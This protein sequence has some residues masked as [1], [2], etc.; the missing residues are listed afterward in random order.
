MPRGPE[1]GS[2]TAWPAVR[3]A[4]LAILV[5]VEAG[6][7]SDRLLQARETRFSDLR[8]RRFMHHLVLTTLRWQEAL[9]RRL[10][11]WVR[12][13]WERLD[14]LTRNALRLGLAQGLLLDRPAP[15][16]VDTTIEAAKVAGVGRAAG[17]IN[18]VLRRAL[19]D[20][21]PLDP[22][23]TVPAWLLARWEQAFGEDRTAGIVHAI[24]EPARPFIVVRPDRGT[25]AELA[26]RLAAEG[27][28]TEPAHRHPWGLSVLS[29]VPQ[30][31]R[32]FAAGDFLLLDEAAALVALLAA[33]P[34]ER[35]AADLTAAP[36]GKAACLAQLTRGPLL[37]LELVESRARSLA[38]MLADR[39]PAGRARA[40]RADAGQPPLL[41]GAFGLV[42]L[43]APCSGSGTL[44]RRPEKRFR[45]TQETIAA[46]AARQAALLDTAVE[47]VGPGGVLVYGV[48]SIEPE[49]GAEQVARFLAAHPGFRAQD[50]AEVL[51]AAA[52]G[53]VEGDPPLLLTIPDAEGMEGFAA[54]RLVRAG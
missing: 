31:S 42:L 52:A 39:A 44:R 14:P 11:P 13:G 25:P 33:P 12:G 29:G 28:T 7:W 6:G 43:D 18:A 21:K 17:L 45:L 1:A 50:P 24:N 4:A 49:E 37:A 54:A 3:A 40:V 34:D 27:V 48:C 30:A 2:K 51:G 32:S 35:P 46:C 38:Q 20:R 9:D 19:V 23:Q 26:A 15:I 36:G 8:D 41:R 16:A 10:A 53:L 47:L 22:R 5:E